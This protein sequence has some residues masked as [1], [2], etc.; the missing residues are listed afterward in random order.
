MQQ[1]PEADKMIKGDNGIIKN[2]VG[3]NNINIAKIREEI[4]KIQQNHLIVKNIDND[5]SGQKLM[6]IKKMQ[7]IIKIQ[8]KEILMKIKIQIMKK[9]TVKIK[10]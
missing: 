4:R 10:I 2:N 5:I 8:N 3:H 9:R 7:N 1:H 6:K